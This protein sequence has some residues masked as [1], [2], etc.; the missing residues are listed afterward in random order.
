MLSATGNVRRTGANGARGRWSRR[1]HA[2]PLFFVAPAALLLSIWLVYPVLYTIVRSFFDRSG[3]HWIGLG[4]YAELFTS[5]FLVTAIKNNALWVAVVPAVVTAFGLILAVLTERISWGAA[6]RLVVFMPMAISLFTAGVIWRLVYEK[7]PDRGALNAVIA[8][9]QE[10]L[11]PVGELAEAAPSSDAVRQQ[12]AGG[13]ALAKSLSPGHVALLG[14]TQISTNHVPKEAVDAVRPDSLASG[15]SGVVWRDFRPGGGIP[16]TVER[17]E[18]GL[19]AVAVELENESGEMVSETT[20]AADGTFTFTDVP[21]G[22]YVVSIAAQ[23]FARPFEGISWLGASLIT[24]AIMISYTWVWTG[25]ALVVIA[26]GLAVLPR[27]LLDAARLDGASEGQVLRHITVPLLAPV[28]T[29]VFV[30][31][32]INVLKVFDVVLA[33][34][35]GSVQDDANVIA[36]AMWRT[37]FGGRNDF[38]LASAIAVLLLVLVLPSLFLNMRRFR[39]EV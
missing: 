19:P 21:R 29:A 37:A 38:G 6:F 23:N 26:A 7:E 34:A 1:T 22:D 36:L 33:I 12:P 24:P 9:G 8:A 35:P 13:L 16:G 27:E 3:E 11:R 2:V 39:R 14:L 28:L 10:A 4:N 30:T 32:L 15:I 25:F 5:D 20:T 31:M 17:E 18:L